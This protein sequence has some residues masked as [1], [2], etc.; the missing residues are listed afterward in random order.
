MEM[1]PGFSLYRGLYEFSQYAFEGNYMGTGGIGWKDLSDGTNGMREVLIIMF[2]EWLVVLFAA[3][4]I[5]Q[6]VASG[7]GV[8]RSPLFFLQKSQKKSS[9]SSRT[10]SL[11]RQRSTVTVEMEKED[12]VQ[13]VLVIWIIQKCSYCLLRIC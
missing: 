12:I 1:Y 2:V 11:R 4:Y 5:D 9:S 10:P 8:G 3:Y 7:S 13:E 6:V